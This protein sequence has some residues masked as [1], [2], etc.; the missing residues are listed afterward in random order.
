MNKLFSK[1]YLTITFFSILSLTSISVLS[2]TATAKTI[3]LIKTSMGDIQV[4]LFP[5]EAPETVKNFI[6]L[7]EG[8]KDFTDATT[9]KKHKKPFYDG[10]IFHRVINKFMIQGGDPLGT[11]TGS[12]G[13]K[14]KDEINGV[15]LG[16]DKMKV[17]KDGKFHPWLGRPGSR[18]FATSILMPVYKKLGITNKAD[19]TKREKEF[20]AELNKMTLLDV[21]K[22]MGYQYNTTR[23]SHS[24]KRGALAMANSGPN[25][26]GSQFFIN[27]I[28]TPWLT[29]KHTVFGQVIKGMDIVDKISKAPVGAGNKPVTVIKIISIRLMK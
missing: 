7:A 15:N 2:A 18:Q 6:G 3:V 25:T 11:G 23:N 12:P 28:D 10:L 20:L 19:A 9:G 22:N 5:E 21:Y 17:M 4:Q 16:L 1:L 14:F 27:I 26:N 13:Y 29:G 8:K 24:P